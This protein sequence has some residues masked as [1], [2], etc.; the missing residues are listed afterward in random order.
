[1]FDSSYN[2]KRINKSYL[3]GVVKVTDAPFFLILCYLMYCASLILG[4]LLVFVKGLW[5]FG[6]AIIHNL[7]TILHFLFVDFW[8]SLVIEGWNWFLQ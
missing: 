6:K 8:L 5:E 3:T 4:R 2:R 7:S 1:M